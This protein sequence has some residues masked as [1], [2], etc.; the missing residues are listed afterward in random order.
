MFDYEKWQIEHAKQQ[1]AYKSFSITEDEKRALPIGTHYFKAFF[2]EYIEGEYA[3][4]LIG[5]YLT[6]REAKKAARAFAKVELDELYNE[7]L[8]IA[9]YEVTANNE[10]FH[11]KFKRRFTNEEGMKFAEMIY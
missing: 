4:Q 11:G 1:E 5:I 10:N 7:E 8:Y 6:L 9:E 2:R 3:K